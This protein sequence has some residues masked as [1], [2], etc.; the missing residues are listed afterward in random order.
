MFRDGGAYTKRRPIYIQAVCAF[1]AGWRPVHFRS[2]E[3]V[4]PHLNNPIFPGRVNPLHYCHYRPFELE[5][6]MTKQG[7]QVHGRYTQRL[8]GQQVVTGNDGFVKVLVYRKKQN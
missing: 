8:Q 4:Y 5:Q 1:E 6:L 3:N 7:F 2:N